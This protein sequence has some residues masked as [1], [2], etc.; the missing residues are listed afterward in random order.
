M[1][2]VFKNYNTQLKE[3]LENY[4]KYIIKRDGEYKKVVGEMKDLESK[5]NLN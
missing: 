5:L 4:K 2:D 3:T 1:I